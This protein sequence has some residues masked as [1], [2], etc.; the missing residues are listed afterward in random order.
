MDRLDA[1]RAYVQ[2][3]ESGS[4]TRAAQLL[5]VHKGTVSEQVRQLED[6]LG[7]RLLNRTTRSVAPTSEGLDYYRRACVILQQ[8]DEAEAFVR[9]GA[10]APSGLFCGCRCRW[11]SAARSWRRKAAASSIGIRRWCW[12]WAAPTRWST[13]SARAWTVRCEEASCPTRD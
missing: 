6:K 7:C 1:M 9:K 10:R 11:P 3:V 5:D 8:V 12:I 2:V 13:S 4:Y